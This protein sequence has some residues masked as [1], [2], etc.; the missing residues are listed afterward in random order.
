MLFRSISSGVKA[1]VKGRD[2]GMNLANMIKKTNKKK[3]PE[4]FERLNREFDRIIDK[5]IKRSS[6]SVEEAK[7]SDL[8]KMYE[9]KVSAIEVLSEGL[10]SSQEVIDRISMIFSDDSKNGICLSTIH[11]SKGLESDRVFIIREDKL[12]LK[13]CMKIPWM[14]EQERNLVYVA[15]KRAKKYLGFIQDF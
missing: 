2:V 15:Y 14:A 9:D 3:M 10:S 11:K 12:Y 6:C 4:V 7:D 5:V 8:Y 1:Y 13:H